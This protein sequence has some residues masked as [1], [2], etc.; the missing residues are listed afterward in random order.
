MRWYVYNSIYNSQF[1]HSHSRYPQSSCNTSLIF[2]SIHSSI[3][4][5][6]Y[7]PPTNHPQLLTLPSKL[8]FSTLPLVSPTGTTL[9]LPRRELF[10]VRLQLMAEDDS[11][12]PHLL[13][14]LDDSDLRTNIYEGGYKTWECSIDLAKFLLDRGPRRQLDDL[15]KVQHVIEMGCG[16]AVPS[17]VLFEYAL[18]QKLGMQFTLTDYNVDVLR[19]VTVP[20]LLLT[21]L[22]G[23]EE[24][25][26]REL[27]PEGSP[28]RSGEDHG[29]VYLTPEIVAAFKKALE[30][31]GIT[32]TLLSGSWVPVQ[33]LLELVPSEE[34]LNTFI[35]G[36]ETIYSPASLVA[37]T[38]AIVGLMKRVRI[39]KTLVAAKKVYFGVGGS[40]DGFRDECVQRG[41]VTSEVDF[42]G[43]DGGEGGS[44]VRRCLVEVQMC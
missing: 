37:F 12:S 20:N 19:L 39:A 44:G 34:G 42:E 4:P 18:R 9:T 36:S 16:S 33:R 38:E 35:L 21:Y 13:A 17:L 31:S 14:G 8:S 25:E 27:F 29:D 6:Q 30:K 10:D 40:V 22:A 5:S 7:H 11:T 32:V 2:T 24:S 15:E 1:L 28:F 26:A 41:C 43:L 23:L 3:H